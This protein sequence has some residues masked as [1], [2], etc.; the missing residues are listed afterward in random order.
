LRVA[1]SQGAQLF[2]FAVGGAA[3]AG[4]GAR[5][6]LALDAASFCVSAS[7]IRFGLRARPAPVASAGAAQVARWRDGL[8]VAFASRHLRVLL[9]FSWL[10]G[11]F[12]VPE[13]LAAPY[14][15]KIGGGALTIGVLLAANP[16][17][18]LVG[19]VVFIR[20]LPERSRA[21]VAGPMAVACGLPLLLCWGIPGLPVVTALLALS[22][23]ALAY[24]VQVMTEFV[25]AIA[26]DRRGQAIAVASAGLLAAQG[27][28]LLAGGALAQARTVGEAIAISGAVGAVI[29]GGLASIRKRDLRCA[30]PATQPPHPHK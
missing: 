29:A 18:L 19:S 30:A 13:G 10:A 14:A 25:T 5:G 12:I 27:L 7:L 11:L 4:I 1:T 16:A 15:A 17:G 22:G 8:G 3:V 23:F 24:Q 28:G 2:G 9:G 21:R 26:P 6:A 20:W